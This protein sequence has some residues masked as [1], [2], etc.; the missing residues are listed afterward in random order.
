MKNNKTLLEKF[1]NKL[2]SK[3]ETNNKFLI[4][5]LSCLINDQ[6]LEINNLEKYELYSQYDKL[7]T[8]PKS[9]LET[10]TEGME[11]LNL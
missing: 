8:N 11:T 1:K 3:N 5:D 6:S 2:I 4:S 10:L 9:T 7:Y